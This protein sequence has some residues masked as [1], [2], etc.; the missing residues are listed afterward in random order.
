MTE[1]FLRWK[2]DDDGKFTNDETGHKTIEAAAKEVSDLEGGW[3][4][5]C[6]SLSYFPPTGAVR[7]GMD[8]TEALIE[9]TFEH[10]V[11]GPWSY[12]PPKLIYD[13]VDEAFEPIGDGCWKRRTGAYVEN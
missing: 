2:W 8:C 4:A 3:V 13:I 5:Q 11:E 1:Y 10:W 12:D 9:A 7:S 6:F